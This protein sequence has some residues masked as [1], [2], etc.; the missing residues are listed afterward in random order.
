[1]IRTA[2]VVVVFVVAVFTIV[3][4]L[5]WIFSNRRANHNQRRELDADRGTKR[6]ATVLS[7]FNFLTRG[8]KSSEDRDRIKRNQISLTTLNQPH[9]PISP[10]TALSF[11]SSKNDGERSK[12]PWGVSSLNG[13]H[14]LEASYESGGAGFRKGRPKSL[15]EH[16][17]N[18]TER[19]LAAFLGQARAPHCGVF[20]H[21]LG[22]DDLEDVLHD[23]GSAEIAPEMMGALGGMGVGS[24]ELGRL[25]KHV[26][27]EVAQRRRAK[28]EARAK[29]R[30]RVAADMAG[31]LG[32]A[33]ASPSAMARNLLASVSFAGDGGGSSGG[34]NDFDSSLAGAHLHGV[35]GGLEGL[36]RSPRVSFGGELPAA[37]SGSLWRA[38][39]SAEAGKSLRGSLRREPPSPT[40]A[41]VAPAMPASPIWDP[42]RQ[43]LEEPVHAGRGQADAKSLR[44]SSGGGGGG[45]GDSGGGC[46]AAG[47][48]SGGFSHAAAPAKGNPTPTERALFMDLDDD[49]D[50]LVD[51]LDAGTLRSPAR[52]QRSAPLG[53]SSLGPQDPPDGEG[54]RGR[55]FL[56]T[57][58]LQ[59]AGFGG[60]GRRSQEIQSSLGGEGGSRGHGS[61]EPPY[62]GGVDRG[63]RGRRSMEP[64]SPGGG[65][66]GSRGRRSMEPP[67]PGGA[68]RGSRGHR[69]MEPSSPGGGGSGS[70]GRRPMEPPS[71]NGVDRGGRGRRPMEP[72]SPG[73]VD[74][75]S[76]GRRSMEPPSPGGVNRGGRGRR[77]M[78]PP[79]PDGSS[80]GPDQRAPSIAPRS[81]SPRPH[82]H[83][84]LWRGRTGSEHAM[85]R[86]DPAAGAPAEPRLSLTAQNFIK[87]GEAGPPQQRQ[88]QRPPALTTLTPRST[89][90]DQFQRRSSSSVGA[91]NFID[92]DDDFFGLGAL[93]VG[94]GFSST[95]ANGRGGTRI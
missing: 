57:S 95:A 11:F 38:R 13:E 55:L 67:S 22:Y 91:G 21:D 53:R 25:A 71:P 72:P 73:G 66:S 36:P 76:R 18:R 10:S 52:G 23:F 79:S 54:S 62:P 31:P 20:L 12:L 78:E 39:A 14:D 44:S 93:L 34:G 16:H 74:R 35:G 2:L 5:A 94:V 4:C 87:A 30:A 84:D 68:D 8:G 64:S 63:S 28:D 24:E 32:G 51:D 43:L 6:E 50:A 86:E 81:S 59:L 49:D 60:G 15:A 7:M 3:I 85:K 37:P 90:T 70:R 17:S 1:M 58:L 26:R 80:S 88:R 48:G 29:H 33:V 89:A 69:S 41:V 75:G 9:H 56:P 40:P 83:A 27:E 82:S 45:G 77:S 46:S 61:K 42:R 47:G 92:G 19:K 65:G